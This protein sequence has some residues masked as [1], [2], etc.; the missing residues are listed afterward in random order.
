MF[1]LYS[2]GGV[3]LWVDNQLVIDRWQAPSELET[4]SA[5]VDL[6]AG[7]KADVRVEYYNAGGKARI[8]LL[9]N[10]ASTPKQ[11]IPQRHL[12]PE[13]ATNKSAPADADKQTGMLLPPGSDAGP[14][15]TRPQ[16][17][18]WLAAR[19]GRAGLALLIAGCLLA[20]LLSINSKAVNAFSGVAPDAKSSEVTMLRRAWSSSR[21][22][23]SYLLFARRAVKVLRSFIALCYNLT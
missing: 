14:K 19:P 16:P 21:P 6:K 15:A 23:R 2:N 7:E 17:S 9:W 22:Q 11:I 8:H 10:S 4:R 3:R 1:Y 12:Y 5:P 20:L 13:A 18:G